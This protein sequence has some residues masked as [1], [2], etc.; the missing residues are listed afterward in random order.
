MIAAFEPLVEPIAFLIQRLRR[1]DPSFMKSDAGSL[2][3]Y[4]FGSQ[5]HKAII[6]KPSSKHKM[7]GRKIC[8][9]GESIRQILE[10]EPQ[11]KLEL[12]G[13]KCRGRLTVVPVP[14]AFAKGINDVIEGIA[15]SLVKAIE[16]VKALRDDVK[17]NVF[18]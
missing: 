17:F 14:L 4:C 3:L 11:A 1:N 7:P 2:L 13:V 6:D 8:P 18:G 9:A 15:G 12:P 5:R 10:A 16:Q